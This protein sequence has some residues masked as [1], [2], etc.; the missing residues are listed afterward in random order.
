MVVRSREEIR[1]HPEAAGSRTRTE[2]LLSEIKRDLT[3]EL[4]GARES[5]GDP[6]EGDPR[7]R[8]ERKD[9]ERDEEL[10]MMFPG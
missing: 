7:E 1:G 9:K 2:M 4:E 5:G 3:T 10:K 6:R 8:K